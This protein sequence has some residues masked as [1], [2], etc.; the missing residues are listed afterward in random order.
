MQPNEL[1]QRMKAENA[2]IVVDVR[3]GIEFRR[4]HIPG[5]LHA[6][7]W[8]ILLRLDKIPS[9]RNAELVI[10][11]EHGPRARIAESLLQAYGHRNIVLLDGHMA[12]WRRSG[13]PLQK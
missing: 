4:G 8:K 5:A 9:D 7:T 13:F 6:P 2:P 3:T 12:G 11:C 1:M 10:T